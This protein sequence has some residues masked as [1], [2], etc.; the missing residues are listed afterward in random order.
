MIQRY[1]KESLRRLKVAYNRIFR[2]LLKLEHRISMSESFIRVGMNPFPVLV[3]KMVVSFRDRILSSDN[4]IIK[5]IVNSLFFTFSA[6]SANWNK[7]IFV[8]S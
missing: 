7:L 6:M 8:M 3:R 4:V 2:I 1:K 5:A